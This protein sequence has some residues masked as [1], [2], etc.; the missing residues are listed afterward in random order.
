MILMKCRACWEVV[1]YFRGLGCH[2]LIPIIRR[3]VIVPGLVHIVHLCA[4]HGTT[5]MGALFQGGGIVPE[6]EGM[7]VL[8]LGR[9]W[10]TELC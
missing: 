5:A 4:K 6:L 9:W 1:F 8:Q 2:L 10:P 3:E 7:I